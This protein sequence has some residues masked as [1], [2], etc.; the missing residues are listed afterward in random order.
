MIEEQ[1]VD[2][3]GYWTAYY[4]NSYVLG[5][6]TKL[7]KAQDVPKNLRGLLNPR[8]KGGQISLDTEAYGMME[9]L[10]ARVGQRKRRWLFK[11]LAASIR[12]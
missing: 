1:L 8:W 6:N 4:V 2:K 5:W 12:S 3:Q 10:E 11:R 9:G 7:V